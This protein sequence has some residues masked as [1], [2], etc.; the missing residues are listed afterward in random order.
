MDILAQLLAEN[1]LI[2]LVAAAAGM[3]IAW[4]AGLWLED[5]VLGWPVVFRPGDLALVAAAG[6]ALALATTFLP[7]YRAASIS[8]VTVL[9]RT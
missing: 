6:V 8:P 5:R 3:C 1:A 4:L 9:A 2:S 7:A